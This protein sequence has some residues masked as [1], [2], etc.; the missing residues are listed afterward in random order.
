MNKL[1]IIF[2]TLFLAALGW[3]LSHSIPLS[4]AF[5]T[6]EPK[7][8]KQCRKVE[9]A[10][11]TEDVT[12]DEGRNGAFVSAADRR[13]WYNDNGASD[14]NPSNGIYFLS[15]DQDNSVRKVS[16]EM[17]GFLPHGLYLWKGGEQDRMFVVN[18]PPSGEEIIEIFDVAANGDLTHA[19]SI[20]FTEMHSPNDVVG[21]GPRSFYATN[22]RGFET[23]IM[24]T[25][26]AYL[27]LPF[28]SIVY[29]DG[30]NGEVIK[31]GMFYANGINQSADGSEIYIAEIL[32]RRIGIFDRDIESGALTRSK[33]IR[34][35][36]APDNI[37]V[38][39]DGALWT[40]G[41]SKIFDFIAHAKDPAAIA[42]SHAIR[43]D[44]ETGA[45]SD[46]FISI[47]GEINGSSVAA[48]ND[49]TLLVG[50]VFDSHVMICPRG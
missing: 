38:A 15:F 4:G 11:G 1:T 46:E 36:T 6:L 8:V 3:V 2:A 32:K 31:D 24:A 39:N 26:E 28:S 20:S 42:P 17:N 45:T 5:A 29:F 34:V 30:E 14:V 21:V 50:A 22:D 25:L 7:L 13:A 49:T 9:I 37:E 44:P 12:I 41:H 16:P 23:G 35:E 33:T 40:A 47:R 19:D 48:A 18:H 27:T 10:P 43:I